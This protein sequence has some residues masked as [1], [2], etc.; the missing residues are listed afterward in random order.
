MERKKNNIFIEGS[1]VLFVSV[2]LRFFEECNI[3]TDLIQLQ[4]NLFDNESTRAVKISVVDIFMT[5]QL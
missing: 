4:W 3:P 2:G 1:P 5:K